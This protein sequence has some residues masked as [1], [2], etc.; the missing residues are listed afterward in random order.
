MTPPPHAAAAKCGGADGANPATPARCAT[1]PCAD[2]SSVAEPPPATLDELWTSS[3]APT[4]AGLDRP[5]SRMAVSVSSIRRPSSAVSTS[6]RQRT[7]PRDAAGDIVFEQTA[8]E[9]EGRPELERCRIGRGIEAAGPQ[10]SHWSLVVSRC[11]PS[12]QSPR[13]HAPVP[14]PRSHVP[15]RSIAL[16]H[17]M[18]V[19]GAGGFLALERCIRL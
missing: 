16:R 9:T 7:A 8:V 12:P 13:P 1:G 17:P 4:N 6:L 2:V 5:S 11:P 14:S 10:C 3:S 15:S 19:G 18:K